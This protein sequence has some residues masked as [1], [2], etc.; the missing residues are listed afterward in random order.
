M[1]FLDFFK[2]EKKEVSIIIPNHVKRKKAEENIRTKKLD[3][4]GRF[5]VE[6][7][8]HVGEIMMVKGKVQ[9]GRVKANMKTVICN[10]KVAIEEVRQRNKKIDNLFT[11]EKGTLFLSQ[12]K[13]RIKTGDLLEFK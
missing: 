1:A 2:K 6:E 4:I 3:P 12:K 13:I 10:Q 7:W 5:L 9:S 8:L 11:G